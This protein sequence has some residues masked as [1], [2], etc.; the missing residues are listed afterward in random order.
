MSA[1]G[2]LM[3]SRTTEIDASP[4]TV[5]AVLADPRQHALI[6]GSGTL[7]SPISGPDRLVLGSRFGMRMRILLPYV[8][9]NVVVEF[10]PDRCIAWRH[11]AGHRWRFELRPLAGGGTAVTETFDFSRRGYHLGLRLLRA[12]ER[13]TAA[14]EATLPRLK[15]LAE[16]R[17]RAAGGAAHR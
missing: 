17:E 12:R 1:G 14:I 10:E 16:S 8:I 11:F 5:F 13:N 7:R 6:D 2:P 3:V 15:A 9:T 4:P